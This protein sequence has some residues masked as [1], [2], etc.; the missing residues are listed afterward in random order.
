[1]R[2]AFVSCD[3]IGHSRESSI[4]IQRGRI[5]AINEI[6]RQAISVHEPSKAV[7]ASGGDG[8]HI[9][10]VTHDFAE[11]AVNLIVALRQWSIRE[12]V[13]LRI[14]GN[15]GEV[16]Q[17]KG[18]DGRVQMVGHGINLAGRLLQ[19]SDETRV[20]V[21]EEFREAVQSARLDRIRFHDERT[22]QVIHFSPQLVCLLSKDGWFDS[23]WDGLP[24]HTDRGALRK[25]LEQQSGLEVIY[26]A[27]RLLQVN[28]N[29]QDAKDAL[30]HL[31]SAG[32]GFLHRNNLMSELLLDK[33]YGE[34]YVYGMQLIERKKGDVL[35]QA[36]D[37]GQ[38]MFMILRGQLAGYFHVESKPNDSAVRK[39]NFVIESGEFAGELAFALQR[40]RT[41]TLQCSEDTALLSFSY[42][43]FMK[44]LS[45]SDRRNE[46]EEFLRRKIRLRIV[47]HVCNSAHFL[48]GKRPDGP[49][50][51]PL[52]YLKNPWI[53]LMPF[54]SSGSCVGVFGPF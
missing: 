10:F 9:A 44:S 15:C 38:T 8:G 20:V 16:E 52:A 26:R 23:R 48:V 46:L 6:V 43:E 12:N 41:A 28:V 40:S 53:D 18:A 33:E 1:M 42:S 5:A 34:E 37:E 7:W 29:D 51:G 50:I 3:I 13:P 14:V 25:A 47:E 36:G 30:R 49:A 21:T 11:S 2:Y 32:S 27:K 45:D 24:L 22:V 54:G 17:I 19:L 4:E 39:P 35:C 31:T